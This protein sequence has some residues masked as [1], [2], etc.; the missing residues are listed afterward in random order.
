MSRTLRKKSSQDVMYGDE[1]EALN[2]LSQLIEKIIAE[3]FK[4]DINLREYSRKRLEGAREVLGRAGSKD[5]F[6]DVE[7]RSLVPSGTVARR[8][9]PNG[10]KVKPLTSE[11]AKATDGKH[12]E[13]LFYVVSVSRFRF[14]CGCQDA[15]M[16]S[17]VADRRLKEA[18]KMIGINRIPSS[19]MV[20]YKY[21]LCKHTLA[22][23]AKAMT[24]EGDEAGVISID[25]DFINTLKLALFGAYLR[26][27]DKIDPDIVKN[28]YWKTLLRRLT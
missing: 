21:V 26:A 14:K 18:L 16:L 24:G 15:L 4:N 22:K 23:I 28:I 13:D 8:W 27:T 3:D 5:Y 20:F 17:S 19:G 2:M 1:F 6:T 10:V 9:L 25:K 11:E 12:D 7:L